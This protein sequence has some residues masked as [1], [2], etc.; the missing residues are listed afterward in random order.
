MEHYVDRIFLI[1][2]LK[3]DGEDQLRVLR[4]TNN[5]SEGGIVLDDWEAFQQFKNRKFS[6]VL[7]RHLYVNRTPQFNVIVQDFLGE[8][9]KQPHPPSVDPSQ[10][11]RPYGNIELVANFYHK[12]QLFDMENVEQF[13]FQPRTF[14]QRFD[15]GL[16][17]KKG[18]KLGEEQNIMMKVI[19]GDSQGDMSISMASDLNVSGAGFKLSNSRVGQP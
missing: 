8:L 15:S 7:F 11:A 19:E 9:K 4:S 12:L 17:M 10:P 6:D 5:I 16:S 2:K 3:I 14:S 18:V 13:E 1:V